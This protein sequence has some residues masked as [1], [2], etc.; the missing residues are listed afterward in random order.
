MNMT[1]TLSPDGPARFYRDG[2]RIGRAAYEA[3]M[4]RA[5]SDGTLCCLST[6]AKQMPGGTF[7]RWNYSVISDRPQR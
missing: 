3:L 1:Q 2:R 5:Y 6:K 4:G 7:K